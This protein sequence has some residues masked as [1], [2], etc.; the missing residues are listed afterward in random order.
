MAKLTI[1]PVDRFQAQAQVHLNIQSALQDFVNQFQTQHD[2]I[3]SKLDPKQAAQFSQWW[4]N[5]STCVSQHATL[6]E[7]LALHLQNA[8]Q[9]YYQLDDEATTAFTPKA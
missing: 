4:N 8:G 1:P 3:V 5:L 2:D 7:Q 9:S 6:H